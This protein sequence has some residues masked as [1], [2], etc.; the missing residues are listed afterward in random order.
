LF[1]K[2]LLI[3]LLTSFSSCNAN[4]GLKFSWLEKKSY[5]RVLS[6]GYDEGGFA[7]NLAGGTEDFRYNKEGF[8]E[9]GYSFAMKS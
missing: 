3:F 1:F 5:T 8:V 4:V 9:N 6:T 2:N 7:P